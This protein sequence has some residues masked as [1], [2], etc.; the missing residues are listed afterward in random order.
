MDDGRNT[1][2]DLQGDPF[3]APL[4]RIGKIIDCLESD[5]QLDQDDAAWLALVL[6]KLTYNQLPWRKALDLK[7]RGKGKP[8]RYPEAMRLEIGELAQL[9]QSGRHK[10]EG[11]TEGSYSIIGRLYGIGASTV[12]DYEQEYIQY[13]E[14]MEEVNE[15]LRQDH[16]ADDKSGN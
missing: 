1:F 2:R 14:I 4:I 11:E 8:A 15:E 13:R 7:P 5:Q 10:S 6:R 3:E 16:Q 12:Q 9:H